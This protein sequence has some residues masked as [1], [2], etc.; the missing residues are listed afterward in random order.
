[1]TIEEGHRRILRDTQDK[2]SGTEVFAL[3]LYSDFV[4]TIFVQ[5]IEPAACIA[6]HPQAVIVAL[7]ERWGYF[8]SVL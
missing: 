4:L 8:F 2:P 7:E 1:M 3:V 6:C 5:G